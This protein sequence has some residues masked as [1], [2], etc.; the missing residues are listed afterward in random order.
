MGTEELARW[1]GPLTSLPE[2]QSLIPSIH[3]EAQ[4]SVLGSNALFSVSDESY[5]L[6]TY[7]KYINKNTCREATEGRHRWSDLQDRKGEPVSVQVG[8]NWP[9]PALVTKRG[10]GSLMFSWISH[11]TLPDQWSHLYSLVP[12][13][14]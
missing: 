10:R 1:L 13:P 7:I 14:V 5:S 8:K 3:M 6:L 2:V 4:P 12:N 11:E 9:V